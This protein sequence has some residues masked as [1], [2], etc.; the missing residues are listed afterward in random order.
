MQRDSENMVLDNLQ[1]LCQRG[2]ELASV[3]D[4]ESL[5]NGILETALEMCNSSAASILKL[6]EKTGELYFKAVIDEKS[7]DLKKIRFDS[8]LGIAGWVIKNRESVIVNDVSSDPRHYKDID[9]LINFSTKKM[10]C[11]PVL[12]EDK[13]IG[14]MEVLNKNGDGP[15]TNQDLEYLTIL[16]NHAGA[17]MHITEMMGNLQNFFVNMLEILMMATETLGFEQGHSVR[18]ARLAMKIAREMGVSEKHYKEIY[19]ASLIHDIGRIKVARDHIVGG[20]R[21]IPALGAEM[22]K[23]VTM[24]K[25]LAPVLESHHERWDGSGFPKGMKGDEIP[26]GSRIIG[27]AEDYVEWIEEESFKNQYDPFLQDDFFRTINRIHDP[28]VVEAFKTIRRKDRESREQ[29]V[30]V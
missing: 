3:S 22:I 17:S 23:P 11:V 1:R 26:L 2:Q 18:I 9:H 14:V 30:Q 5:L 29:P 7:E 16:A 8:S 24:L 10:I 20:E 6:D 12:W 25:S 4:L 15:Y 28:S 19:Y 21:M 27:L 13:I